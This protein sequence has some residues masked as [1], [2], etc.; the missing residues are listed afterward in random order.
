MVSDRT[1]SFPPVDDLVRRVQSHVDRGHVTALDTRAIVEPL[2]GAEQ[3][4]NMFMVG[5]AYQLGALS[6]EPRAVEGAIAL[7]GVAVEANVQ[8][9]RRGRQL[10][11][12]PDALHDAVALRTATSAAPALPTRVPVEVRATAGSELE[13]LVLLRG[14]ELVA[15]QDEAYALRYERLVER[16]RVAETSLGRADGALSEAV[17]RYYF[18]LLAYKDEYEVARLALDPEVRE[19]VAQEA[20]DDARTRW[21]LHPPVLRAI[22]MQRKISLGSWFGVVFAGLH[23]MRR[24]RGT[25]LDP[26]G[27]ARVRKVERDLVTEYESTVE[28][29]LGRLDETTHAVAVEIAELPDLVRGF[30]HVKLRSVDV[31]RTRLA[32]GLAALEGSQESA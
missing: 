5:V 23:R 9:F 27:Y 15:Y 29:L 14:A 30:E 25:F 13:R 26:F 32:E 1:V 17:A 20:G 3:L 28:R 19:Q 16:V 11:A 18:K 21:R 12:D 22:G 8:A 4:A 7:N 6:L 31:Y 24:L 2:F 10:V